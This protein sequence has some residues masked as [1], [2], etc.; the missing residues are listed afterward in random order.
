MLFRKSKR[1]TQSLSYE[2]ITSICYITHAPKMF[3]P[4]FFHP[5]IIP[6]FLIKKKP[7]KKKTTTNSDHMPSAHAAH[8]LCCP[9]H[10]TGTYILRYITI[11]HS[12]EQWMR[13]CAGH[14]FNLHTRQPFFVYD[15]EIWQ[16]RAW[17]KGYQIGPADIF[18]LLL[19]LLCIFGLSLEFCD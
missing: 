19:L 17:F 9:S 7:L 11:D 5:T 15:V 16:L 10:K 2:T 8:I 1:I 3:V 18:L 6:I 13:L 12:N 14:P 4:V